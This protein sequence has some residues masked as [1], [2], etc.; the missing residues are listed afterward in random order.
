[1]PNSILRKP[2]LCSLASSFIVLLTPFNNILESSRD[3]T[4]FKMSCISSFEII[5]VVVPDPRI[6]F[7]YCSTVADAAAVSP[8]I[9]RSLI[10]DSNKVNTVFSNGHKSL[11]SNSS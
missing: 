4:I 7:V 10:T 8:S 1:M 11:P 5:R 3:I 6:F 2:P 9:P